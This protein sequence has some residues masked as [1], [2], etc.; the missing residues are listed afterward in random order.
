MTSMAFILGVL[1]ASDRIGEQAHEAGEFHRNRCIRRHVGRHISSDLFCAAIL[2][3][4]W[5]N[6]ATS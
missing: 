1:S 4:D 2:R 5:K 3:I 6:Q